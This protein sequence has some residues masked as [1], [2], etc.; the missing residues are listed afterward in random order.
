M[1]SISRRTLLASAPLLAAPAIIKARAQGK[2]SVTFTLPWV[3]E[4]SNLVAYVARAN[5]YWDAAG[6]DVKITRG[7]GSVA[8][9]QAVG[10]GQ[11][12]FGLAAASAGIQQVA[13][14]LPV[15]AIAC[16]G[17]DSTMGIGVLDSS[18]I[19]T[20]KDLAGKTLA[21]T[22][23]SGEY[24]FLPAYF[25]NA[26]IDPAS[27]KIQGT[28]PQVR[29]RVLI[30]QSVDAI[31]GFAISIAPVVIAQKIP[32]RFMLF[33]AAN[34]KQ[35]NNMLLT[36]ATTLKNEPQLCRDIALGL[37][38][39]NRDVLLDPDAAVASFLKQLPE[40]GMTANG[41]ETT[42]IGLG[43]YLVNMIDA[44]DKA[45]GIGYSDPKDYTAMIDMVMQYAVS[46]GDKR[47]AVD[48]VMTNQVIGNVTL[49]A[50]EWQLAEE[51]AAPF[52]QY[53]S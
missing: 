2:R 30:D 46:P 31:S 20:P 18:P 14:G 53:L 38:R 19:K 1:L 49:S 39:A 52:R 5:G 13:K 21:C 4:G 32:V 37:A 42:R 43:I 12:E 17:Y 25:R 8:A 23:S 9:A 11:F 3:A 45:N 34:L 22:L 44:A 24:P 51:K 36:T 16:S 40:V 48:E 41:K 28:D 10:A 33:S 6:L 15:V 27:V 7:F 26:G 50:A 29:T 35:Y 47:P